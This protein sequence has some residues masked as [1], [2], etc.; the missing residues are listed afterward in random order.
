MDETI[1]APAG[2]NYRDPAVVYATGSQIIPNTPSSS[3][4]AIT[5]YSISPALPVGL[6]LDPT[7]GV[8]SGTPSSATNSALYTITGSN[9]AGSATTRVQIEVKAS[10]IAPNGLSYPD[11]P[12][13]YIFGS[14]INPNVPVASGGEITAYAVSPKLPAGLT[15]DPLTGVISGKPTVIA[16]PVAYTITGT[17]SAGSVQAQVNIEV[18]A[19]VVPP[20][21]LSYSD[22]S[23]VYTVGQEIPDDA[24]QVAGGAI[25]TFSVFP[26][27]P[28]GLSLDTQSGV[29]SGTPTDAQKQTS[30]TITGSN[31]AGSVTASINIAI[32]AVATWLPGDSLDSARAFHTATLLPDGKVLVA[33]G[34]GTDGILA[35]AELYDPTTATWSTTGNLHTARAGH[36]ATLLPDGRVLVAG[37]VDANGNHLFSAELYDPAAGTW[38]Q[39]GSLNVARLFHTATLLPDGEVLA[40]GGGGSNGNNLTTAE[41]YDPA[42]GTWSMTGAMTEGR[43][44][45]TATLLQ[46]GQVLVAGGG[47][48]FTVT[49]TP[50]L[51]TYDPATGT[52]TSVHNSSVVVSVVNHT[53]T[54]LPSGKVLIAGG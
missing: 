15:L 53:A 5:K 41:L 19:E 18:Q 16:Q 29:I 11:N 22:P 23:P 33:G 13:S 6:V 21:T 46:N 17:N 31:S 30:Y 44:N 37:G 34:R 51:E 27:L 24:P 48:A 54:L 43:E 10:T 3:G 26:P 35:S 36:T 28:A 12:V 1:A 47:P 32:G 9:V 50:G 39:T 4:G 20:T 2:L 38:S 25:D 49:G 40:A 8:I 52:W 7:T 14:A 42:T 45:H